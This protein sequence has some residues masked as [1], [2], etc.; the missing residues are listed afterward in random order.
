[1]LREYSA[2]TGTVSRSGSTVMARNATTTTL[3]RSAES[4]I[5]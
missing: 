1:M 2:A 4:R 5:G 3:P